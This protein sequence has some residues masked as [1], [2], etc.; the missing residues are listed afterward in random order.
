MATNIG[1]VTVTPVKSLGTVQ[2][3]QGLQTTIAN[4]NYRADPDIYAADIKDFDVSGVENG[5]TFVYNSTTQ[6]YETV[7]I[8]DVDIVLAAVE[9]GTF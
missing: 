7:P 3:K 4:P 1:V 8:S 2:V 5:Y 9:G 6:K